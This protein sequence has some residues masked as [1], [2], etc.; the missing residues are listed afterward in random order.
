[1]TIGLSHPHDHLDL[2]SMFSIRGFW[3]YFCIYILFFDKIPISK[4]YRYKVAYG[5]T[6]G[7]RVYMG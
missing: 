1:M 3:S 2:E 6:I 4:R 5:Q 7:R